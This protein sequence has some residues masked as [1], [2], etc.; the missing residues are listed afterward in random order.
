LATVD[1][2][3]AEFELIL[4]NLLEI[5]NVIPEEK[6]YWKPFESESFIRVYSCGELISHIG[7]LVEYSFNGITSNFWEEPFEWITREVLPT[8][9]HVAAYLEEAARGRRVAFETLTD[10]D[11]PK[12]LHYPDATATTVGEILLTTLSHASHHRGQVYAYVHLFSDA[13]LPT[14]GSRGFRE[15]PQA[16]A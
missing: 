7:G 2:I 9:A 16:G 14:T 6:L 10:A 15:R 3:G 13:R 11:L 4:N 5:L 12:R 1:V 8:R